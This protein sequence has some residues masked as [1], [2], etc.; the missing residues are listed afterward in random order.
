MRK[1]TLVSI[2]MLAGSAALAATPVAM[3]SEKVTVFEQNNVVLRNGYATPAISPMAAKAAASRADETE[4]MTGNQAAAICGMNY[5]P[6]NTFFAGVGPNGKYYT[7]RFGLTGMNSCVAFYNFTESEA[8]NWKYIYSAPN[9]DYTQMVDTEMI[10]DK[11]HLV[12]PTDT[13]DM[14]VSKVSLKSSIEY[15]DSGFYYAGRDL[16]YYGIYDGPDEDREPTEENKLGVTPNAHIPSCRLYHSSINTINKG[17]EGYNANGTSTNWLKIFKEQ[18]KTCD[19]RGYVEYLPYVGSPYQITSM[20]VRYN[21]AKTTAATPLTATVYAVDA[22]GRFTD[23]VVAKGSAILPEGESSGSL[24]IY[25]NSVNALGL[26]TTAP[27]IINGNVYVEL[28][29][30]E[31]ETLASFVPTYAAN[32]VPADFASEQIWDYIYEPHM[33][34]HL[35]G[36]SAKDEEFDG[37]Y[38][39]PWIGYTDNTE[40]NVTLG[41]DFNFFF[42]VEFPVVFNVVD[43]LTK[44]NINIP[45]EGGSDYVGAYSFSEDLVQLIAD[46]ALTYEVSDEWIKVEHTSEELENGAT[47]LIVEASADALPEGVESREG[48]ITFTGYACDFTVTVAQ[49]TAAEGSISEIAG[50]AQGVAEYFDLQGRKLSA[51]PAKGVYIQRTGSTATKLVK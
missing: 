33:Y 9:E 45:A 7:V 34:Y 32:V 50:A 37:I 15:C 18:P 12:V 49:G 29:G 21:S 41:T 46:E 48:T 24:L 1:I 44:F 16:F 36:V 10:S 22:E 13:V 39:N 3:K 8:Y 11:Q 28:S 42:N 19:I 27:A 35:G 30:F 26:T 25:L 4:P 2:A 40:T 38:N 23:E 5:V 17:V 51:A 47:V 20:Y 14:E 6:F 31:A 43:G